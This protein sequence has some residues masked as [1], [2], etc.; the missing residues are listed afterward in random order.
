MARN[1]VFLV[2]G[3]GSHSE[4]WADEVEAVFDEGWK[5]VPGLGSRERRTFIDFVPIRYDQVW[6]EY[7]M[8][9]AEAAGQ[10]QSLVPQ[11]KLR[12]AIEPLVSAGEDDP[13]FVWNSVMDVLLY[14]YAG[15]LYRMAH[16]EV[17]EQVARVV[18][19]RWDEQGNYDTRFSFITHSL[20]TAV[21]HGALNRL[22]G[23]SIAGRSVF[24]LG[25]QFQIRA[26]ISVAN[27]SR[28]LWYGENDIYRSTLIR[29]TTSALGPGYVDTFL[30]VRHV[31]DPFPAARR[32]SPLEW[33]ASYGEVVVNHLYQ[34]NVHDYRHYLR[35]PRVYC[36]ILRSVLG[37]NLV[38]EHV[39]DDVTAGFRNIDIMD[40][41]KRKDA[42]DVRDSIAASL[43]TAYSDDR[44]FPSTAKLVGLVA[45]DLLILRKK[46]G[47]LGELV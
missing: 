33:G 43:R 28:V 5:K 1:V 40:D 47:V 24:R 7:R 35:H 15:D 30:N 17:M 14:R 12:D 38:P 44:V 2:H 3:M 22:A 13:G 16:V 42:A 4:R 29:P 11:A 26:Y 32:F 23:G 6:D 21:T 27:V 25:G 31:A 9:F 34:L 37:T 10:V 41:R 46:L 19:Q 18:Q 8:S 45:R 36:A 20:G 39:V